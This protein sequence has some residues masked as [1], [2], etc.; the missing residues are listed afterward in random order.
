MK[1]S[2]AV[3][4]VVLASAAL[5]R[6][7]APGG[8]DERAALLRVEQQWVNALG[9]RDAAAVGAI[10][11]EDFVDTTYRGERRTREEALAGLTSP[12][13]AETTQKLS[14]MEARLYG[15]VGVVTGVN[16]VAAQNGE[17]TVRVRFTDVF[18]RRRGVWKAVSAQETLEGGR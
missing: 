6:P 17:F 18:V 14:E 8:G 16:T 13:R 3:L 10:L 5:A 7:S 15:N 9:Q 11:A 4:A 2:A 12:S 1:V